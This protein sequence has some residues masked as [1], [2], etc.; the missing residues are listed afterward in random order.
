MNDGKDVYG[1]AFRTADGS[2]PTAG[3]TV[4]VRNSAGDYVQSEWMGYAVKKD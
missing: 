2:A 1:T 3:G 4:Y